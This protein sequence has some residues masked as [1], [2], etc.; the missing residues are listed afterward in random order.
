MSED[1]TDAGRRGIVI[2]D[3]DQQRLFFVPVEEL[4]GYAVPEDRARELF[5]TDGDDVVGFNWVWSDPGRPIGTAEPTF[6]NTVGGYE[7]EGP[8][9]DRKN[10]RYFAIGEVIEPTGW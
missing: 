8:L 4:E 6:Q 2:V 10:D 3:R 1:K 5:G 7:W 9:P